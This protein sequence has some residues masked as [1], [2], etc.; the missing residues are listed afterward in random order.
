MN[1]NEEPIV[2]IE[3]LMREESVKQFPDDSRIYDLQAQR[4]A[5]LAEAVPK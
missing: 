2:A 3:D 4:D 5:L 1:E